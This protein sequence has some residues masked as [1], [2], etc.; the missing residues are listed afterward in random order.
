MNITTLFSWALLPVSQQGGI[1][2]L[3]TATLRHLEAILSM[4]GNRIM[5]QLENGGTLSL[6]EGLQATINGQRN[7]FSLLTEIRP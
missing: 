2:H 7:G 1:L 6:R 4:L 3:I 5:Q